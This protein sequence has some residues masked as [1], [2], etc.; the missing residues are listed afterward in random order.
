MLSVQ[1]VRPAG[2]ITHNRQRLASF[3]PF[4]FYFAHVKCC[5]FGFFSLML[6]I[7]RLACVDESDY[8]SH[9]CFTS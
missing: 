7:M 6:L 8:T 4:L 1:C 3:V 5:M 2:I 9:L